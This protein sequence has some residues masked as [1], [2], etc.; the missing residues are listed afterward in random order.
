MK[1]AKLLNRN[2]LD[3]TKFS[4][5]NTLEHHVNSILNVFCPLQ[6]GYRIYRYYIVKNVVYRRSPM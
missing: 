1:K 4:V 6:N 3:L 5:L 2:D